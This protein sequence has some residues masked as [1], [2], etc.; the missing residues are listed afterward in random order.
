M[1]LRAIYYDTETTGIDGEKDRIIE[2]A[3]YDPINNQTFV[4]L[5]NPGRPI[6]PEATAIHHITDEQVASAPSF[7]EVGAAF[8]EF[9]QGDS[10]L[11]AH[12][13]D[14]FDI[15]FLRHEFKRHQLE[16]P[17]WKFID[18]LKW[19]RRYRPD[20]PRHSLQFLREMYGIPPNNAHRALDDVIVL[21]QLFSM[22]IDD[23]P[24]DKVYQLLNDYNHKKAAIQ[25]MPFGKH[26]GESL[27][28][29]PKSYVRWL[30]D[31]GALD[32][33]ENKELKAAF[34]QFGLLS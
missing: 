13:N 30:A 33:A 9:C 16:M 2:I 1:S 27:E 18:T 24:I 8:I 10:V 21:H 4:Q 17:S 19:A 23:L 32:K 3:A 25:R 12:N 20:L 29:I 6:P 11:I 26:K 5:V 15:H 22:M 31:N 28:K 14:G 7:A 34:E